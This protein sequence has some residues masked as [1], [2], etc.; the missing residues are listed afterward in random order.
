MHRKVSASTWMKC[1][2]CMTECSQWRRH[3]KGKESTAPR[4]L[5]RSLAIKCAVARKE[6]RKGND[7]DN[8]EQPKK[9]ASFRARQ[10]LQ[11]LCVQTQ[12]DTNITLR[13][14]SF[15]FVH[16]M[17][18]SQPASERKERERRTHGHTDR[19]TGRER[20]GPARAKIS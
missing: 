16:F 4:S 3:G 19:Q 10:W 1:F 5:S 2:E 6:G 18:Q 14:S 20:G 9:V 11:S 12:R 7:D 17:R 15:F 8:S 13:S